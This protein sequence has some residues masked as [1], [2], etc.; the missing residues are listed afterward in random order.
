MTLAPLVS[1][2]AHVLGHVKPGEVNAGT[3]FTDNPTKQSKTCQEWIETA[4]KAR[5]AA[6]P[7]EP[8]LSLIQVERQELAL[9]HHTKQI[10]NG[11]QNS[12]DIEEQLVELR[13][14]YKKLFPNEPEPSDFERGQLR[15]LASRFPEYAQRLLDRNQGGRTDDEWTSAFF[16]FCLRS[17][18]LSIVREVNAKHWVEIF[19]LYP[20]EVDQLMASHFDKRLGQYPEN[21]KIIHGKG[22]CLHFDVKEGS[23]ERWVPIQGHLKKGVVFLRNRVNDQARALPLHIEEVYKQFKGKTWGYGDVEMCEDGIVAWSAIDLGSKNPDRPEMDLIESSRWHQALPILTLTYEQ[24]TNLY[25]GQIVGEPKFGMVLRANREF[26]DLNVANTHGFFDFVYRLPDGR[27]R[28]VPTGFQ[29][30]TLPK[31]WWDRLKILASTEKAGMHL[32]DEGHSLTQ[33]EQMKIF[34]ALSEAEGQA[35]I[36]LVS[37]EIDKCRNGSRY[38]QPV[39]KNCAYVVQRIFDRIMGHS[40]YTSLEELAVKHLGESQRAKVKADLLYAVKSLDPQAFHKFVQP[41]VAKMVKTNDIADIHHLITDTIGT[42]NRLLQKKENARMPLPTQEEVA[43]AF[44]AAAQPGSKVKTSDITASLIKITEICMDA[45]HP[46][47]LHLTEGTVAAPVVGLLFRAIRA[48]PWTWLRNFLADVFL[49]ILG[50]WRGHTYTKIDRATG[51]RVT[52]TARLM[53][54]R[55]AG[56]FINLPAK[57]FVNCSTDAWTLRT[58]DINASLALFARNIAI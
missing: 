21:I 12:R 52:K 35:L 16:K 55:N 24:L 19:I 40:F 43:L 54:S 18:A 13:R 45:L 34:Y 1:S 29:S 46:Y 4:Q 47:R 31:T 50:S 17:P 6:A 10:N 53:R 20:D 58:R 32:P 44:A 41:V 5:V 51:N 42:L 2:L 7:K 57:L 49:F 28:I 30:I 8:R 25:E 3:I 9:L 11:S 33:R 48:I 14:T 15:H 56:R 37:K 22:L 27:Y 38:F 23:G 26:M 39:G 36:G